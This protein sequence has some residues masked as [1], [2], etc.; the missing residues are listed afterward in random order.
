[1]SN[2]PKQQVLRNNEYYDIQG[3]F[4]S[5]YKLSKDGEIFDNL[6]ELILSD[7]NILLA[8][9]NIKSNIGSKTSG[10]DGM[11]IKDISNKTPYEIIKNVSFI[12]IG[13]EHGYR[14]KPVRRKDIPKPN[15]SKRPLGIPCIWDRLVQQCIKQVLEPICEAKF[16]NNSFGFRPNRSV[17][18][19]LQKSYRILQRQQMS[20]VVEF[21]IKSFFDE[22]NHSKLIKQIWSLG[23]RDKKLIYIIKQMLKAPIKLENGDVIIPEKGIPQGGI[24][25][26][27]LANIVL[28]ELD[29]WVDSQWQNNK[30]FARY[31]SD[32]GK[33]GMDSSHAFRAM[34]RTALKEMYIVRYADDFRIFCPTYEE[35]YKTKIAITEWLKIR[36]KLDVSPEKTRIVNTKEKYME[37][38]GFKIK[39]KAKN[40]KYIVQSHMSD[41][42][43][44]RVTNDLKIQAKRIAKPR[45]NREVYH[46]VIQYNKMV[47]GIQNYYRYATNINLDLSKIN[48]EVNIILKN[49]LGQERGSRY[50]REGQELSKFEKQKY[51]RSKM[52]RYESTSKKPIYPIGYIKH[53][54]PSARKRESNFYTE[55]GR[56]IIHKELQGNLPLLFKLMNSASK[57]ENIEIADNKISLYSAQYGKCQITGKLFQTLDEIHCHH[58]TPKENGGTDKYNNLVLVLKDIHILI[59]ATKKDTIEKYGNLFELNKTQVKKLNK[60]RIRLGNEPIEDL[61]I[62]D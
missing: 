46:E 5:L 9:R 21:D 37:F 24:L 48:W 30:V 40:N 12:M 20:Y 57:A 32:R 61:M 26:P 4:D 10:T 34:R 23:I 41:K 54:S 35:A 60:L 25:S 6:M 14:P 51:G 45:K 33:K 28:N 52:L 38:L 47:L 8:Y 2:N 59:H 22:V 29:Q 50:Q 19:A 16:S 17:E 43:F 49:R 3:E 13:S 15:G 31:I 42:A 7:K 55:E 53:Y 44:K 18:N 58:K 1:M 62:T 56:K 11:T 27:I 36:L 39:L